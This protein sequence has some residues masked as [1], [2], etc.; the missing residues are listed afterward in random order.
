[1]SMCQ[2]I[3]QLKYTQK[4]VCRPMLYRQTNIL[5]FRKSCSSVISNNFNLFVTCGIHRVQESSSMKKEFQRTD[6]K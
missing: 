2:I 4:I 5:K 3:L 1:M 6:I